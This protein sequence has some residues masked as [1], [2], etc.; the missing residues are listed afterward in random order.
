MYKVNKE[1]AHLPFFKKIAVRTLTNV[2][3][4]SKNIS[5]L[6]VKNPAASLDSQV[7]LCYT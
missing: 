6:Y 7:K 1:I 3:F 5:F 4:L 2:Y